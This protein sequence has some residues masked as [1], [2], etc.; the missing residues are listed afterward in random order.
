MTKTEVTTTL[1]IVDLIPGDP[2]ALVTVKRAV[3]PSG[4]ARHMTQKVLVRDPALAQRL[5]A[6]VQRGDEVTLT[7]TTTWAAENYE[8]DLTN[9]ALPIRLESNSPKEAPTLQTA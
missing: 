2:P 3:N 5:F 6:E 8:T 4:I 9:F 1:T 7:L